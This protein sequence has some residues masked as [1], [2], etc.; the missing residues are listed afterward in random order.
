MET[1]HLGSHSELLACAW[2][3]KNGYEVFRNVSA[4]GAVDI[5]ALKDGK[6]LL[7]NV[8]SSPSLERKSRLS[9]EDIKAGVLPILV[10]P[11][12][13][14]AIDFEPLPKNNPVVC[15]ICGETFIKTGRVQICCSSACYN[16]RYR[17][18]HPPPPLKRSPR[19][20]PRKP[21]NGSG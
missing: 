2:L 16:V 11:N 17:K 20:V 9:A 8:R 13:S 1:K 6:I 5:I 15:E 14:C 3:L 12:G 4:H 19:V 21:S 18:M 7:L 10:T